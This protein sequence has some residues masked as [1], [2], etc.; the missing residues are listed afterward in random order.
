LVVQGPDAFDRW[1]GALEARQLADLTFAEVRRGLQALSSLY[2]ERRG[3]LATGAALEG[4]GKRAAF[5]LYYGPLHFLLVRDVV[6]ALGPAANPAARILDLGCGTGVA[7]AAWALEHG[8]RAS[9]EAVDQSGWALA[10]A[11]W[12]LAQLGLRGRAL[13]ADLRRAALPSGPA[14]VVMAFTANELTDEDRAGLWSRLRS[15]AE[16]GTCVLILEPLAR[17]VAPWW[18]GWR[19][20]ALEAGGRADEWR[21]PATGLPEPVIKLAR[22]AGLDPRERT[23]RSLLLGGRQFS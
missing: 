3:R 15:A 10:E 2:V 1:I 12:T 4:A 22:A 23:A 17:G 5:A 14:G 21:F 11:R 8:G 13:R 6:R 16:R 20:E 7:G 19:R 18:E 9:V